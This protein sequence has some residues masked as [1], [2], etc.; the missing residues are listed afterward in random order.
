MTMF[1]CGRCV[2]ATVR[3]SVGLHN[4]NVC[5]WQVRFG[6]CEGECQPQEVGPQLFTT[7]AAQVL[8]VRNHINF[9]INFQDAPPPSNK[10]FQTL[11]LFFNIV[12]TRTARLL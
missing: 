5:M 12:V 9:L 3:V 4:D 1:V 8:R 10:Y 11:H 2:L 7:S 6:Y